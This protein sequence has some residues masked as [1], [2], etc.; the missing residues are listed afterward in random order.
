V[1]GTDRLLEGGAIQ[2]Y[3]SVSRF[4]N[5][6]TRS[7]TFDNTGDWTNGLTSPVACYCQANDMETMSSFDRSGLLEMEE[8]DYIPQSQ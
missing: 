2:Y 3:S 5:T 8:I 7:L 6:V 4:D 1:P